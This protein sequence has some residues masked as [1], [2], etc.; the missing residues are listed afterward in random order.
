M[1][2]AVYISMK[3]RPINDSAQ[4]RERAQEARR[5]AEQLADAV[6]KQTMLEIAQSYDNLAAITEAR[7]AS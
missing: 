2:A 7:V 5:M 6:A 1:T 3:Q 4:W